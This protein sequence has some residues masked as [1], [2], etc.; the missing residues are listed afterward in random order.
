MKKIYLSAIALLTACMPL[1]AQQESVLHS[2]RSLPQ[3]HYTN[4]AITPQQQFYLGL[5]GI[6]STYFALSNSGFNYNSIFERNENNE[7]YI[8][9][10]RFQERLGKK[11]Y[12]SL[13]G[14]TDLL[15]FGLKINAR[16]FL[17]MNSTVK[18]NNRFMY[19][20][21]LTGLFINGN[22]SYLGE[23]VAFSPAIDH[24]SYLE[25]AI[26]ASYIVN[27]KLTVGATIKQLKG[28]GNIRTEQS[29]FTLTTDAQTYALELEGNLQIRTAGIENALDVLSGEKG[30]D[31]IRYSDFK[32]NGFGIDLGATYMVNNRL[33]VGFSALN[34]GTI[35]WK[36][37]LFEHS[38]DQSKVSFKGLNL[39]EL[40][41]GE[42][43]TGEFVAQLEEE[44]GF[45][46]DD[47]ATITDKLEGK[48]PE[49]YRTGLPAQFYLSARY[50]LARNLHANGLLFSE[51]YNGRFMPAFSAAIN[52]EFGRRLSTS[53]SYTMVNRSYNNIGAGLSFRLTP[54][55]LYLVSDNIISTPV[56]YRSAKALNM[57]LGMNLVFGYRKSQSKLPY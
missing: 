37:D 38:L 16:M 54:F 53:L 34:L 25:N 4:P 48:E 14:Q 2:M 21:G 1:L 47:P 42:N 57:R 13:L 7:R 10:D 56:F 9:L 26:G 40:A 12:L 24:I 19:P 8:N 46:S 27:H 18:M 6:S 15:S 45:N 52:K 31:Q 43:G 51:I 5:P 55:Q 33:E 44:F 20:E 50:E 23:S 17:F 35:K 29:D 39:Q 22:G 11:N 32:N 28:I 3:A 49:S 36:D 41:N 30:M